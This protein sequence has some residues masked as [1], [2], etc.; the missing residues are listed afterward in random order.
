MQIMDCKWIVEV[1][2]LASVGK[3]QFEA[4][5][6]FIS[7]RE[8]TFRP[9]YARYPEAVPRWSVLIGNDNPDGVGILQDTTGG[10]RF[11][12]TA[13][14]NIDIDRLARDRDQLWA[15][16]VYCFKRGDAWWPDEGEAELLTEQQGTRRDHGD[17]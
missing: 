17:A 7:R 6:G 2:E 12:V 13:V 14:G 4:I 16:A 9:P 1:S 3:S 15:E 10:R 11:W 5:K 8:D